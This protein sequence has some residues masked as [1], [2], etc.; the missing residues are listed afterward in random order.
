M[1]WSSI[2]IDLEQ[3]KPYF[4]TPRVVEFSSNVEGERTFANFYP[5]VN[6]DFVGPAGERPPLLVRSHGML[7]HS[8]SYP[9]SVH[10]RLCLLGKF[11]VFVVFTSAAVTDDWSVL[12]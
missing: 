6:G 3:Y 10:E 12:G 4:S 5:P 2:G 11:V 9:H 1:L 8:L 7:A